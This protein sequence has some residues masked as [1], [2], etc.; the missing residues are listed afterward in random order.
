MCVYLIVCYWLGFGVFIY[1]LDFWWVVFGVGCSIVLVFIEYC[2][3]KVF[4]G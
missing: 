2:G 3:L 1:I 4:L